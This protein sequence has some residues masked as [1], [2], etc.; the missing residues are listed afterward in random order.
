MSYILLIIVIVVVLVYVFLAKKSKNASDSV[1]R[2]NH[3]SRNISVFFVLF[4]LGIL[5][6]VLS[7]HSYFGNGNASTYAMYAG[8]L[9]HG[10]A[11]VILAKELVKK[12]SKI[13][14]FVLDFIIIYPLS[15]LGIVILVGRMVNLDH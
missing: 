6:V 8:L 10:I 14:T 7:L 11:M 1:I 15:L 12:F 13:L 9:L 5:L 4:I 2:I 3:T